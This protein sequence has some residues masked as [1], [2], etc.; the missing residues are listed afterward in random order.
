MT[1]WII[2]Q[3]SLVRNQT[4]VVKR[5]IRRVQ[6][7]ARE[8]R[9]K[10]KFPFFLLFNEN[11]FITKDIQTRIKCRKYLRN[12]LIFEIVFGPKQDLL[13]RKTFLFVLEVIWNVGKY[14]CCCVKSYAFTFPWIR[15]GEA[16]HTTSDNKS[17][18]SFRFQF[19]N[20]ISS[21]TCTSR[22]KIKIVYDSC[23]KM[24]IY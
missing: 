20:I 3:R 6:S 10:W 15:I 23:D 8:E 1:I 5:L 4:Y 22:N 13:D 24:M 18:I 7:F 16:K 17:Q 21:K 14:F 19:S 12:G 11:S 2:A 9:K